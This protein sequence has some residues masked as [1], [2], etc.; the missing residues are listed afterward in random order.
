[1]ATPQFVK[2]LTRNDSTV[3]WIPFN[4]SLHVALPRDVQS[5]HMNICSPSGLVTFWAMPNDI[6]GFHS[7]WGHMDY[8]QHNNNSVQT[9]P[10]S[11]V[12]NTFEM[13]M[14]TQNPPVHNPASHFPY[15]YANPTNY[16]SDSLAHNMYNRYF[17]NNNAQVPQ[18]F[19]P[20]NKTVTDNFAQNYNQ[21]SSSNRATNSRK[22][23]RRSPM[24]VPTTPVST[25]NQGASF[26]KPA[27]T[28]GHSLCPPPS[29]VEKPIN[30]STA[31]FNA[32]N[33]PILAQ[34]LDLTQQKS[35]PQVPT[36][37]STSAFPTAQKQSPTSTSKQYDSDET[38][39]SDSPMPLK[40]AATPFEEKQKS[41]S[42]TTPLLD[43]KEDSPS[44]KSPHPK[45]DKELR[46]KLKKIDATDFQC[47]PNDDCY[48]VNSPKD[49][50]P[51][52]MT[53]SL[54]NTPESPSSGKVVF[55]D[56]PAS[57]DSPPAKKPKLDDPEA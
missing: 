9:Y 10:Q 37:Q 2:S 35:A 52:P 12:T 16:Q 18:P 57:P 31:S 44:V 53:T 5:V 32:A 41:T 45:L 26:T 29:E 15:S 42:Y 40:R 28:Q 14:H 21:Q 54:E 46:I 7:P 22:R 33:N 55:S 47:E 20:P 8:M 30:L 11:Q 6:K 43:I 1:M 13:T 38:L 36:P 56:P 34:L 17:S 48:I 19:Y 39:S 51:Q 3:S 49:I 23:P 50:S 27:T 24:P 25:S 4:N